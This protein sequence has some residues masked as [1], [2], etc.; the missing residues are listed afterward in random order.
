MEIEEAEHFA[1]H[2]LERI[3]RKSTLRH[4][5]RDNREAMTLRPRDHGRTRRAVPKKVQLSTL[6]RGENR[7]SLSNMP[8]Q[9]IWKPQCLDHHRG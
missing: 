5:L 1:N 7:K 9:P 4:Q 6:R 3:R 2:L 8:I